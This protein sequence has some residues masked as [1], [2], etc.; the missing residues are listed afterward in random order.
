MLCLVLGSVMLA[1]VWMTVVL[2]LP[3]IVVFG[4]RVVSVLGVGASG[5]GI[6]DGGVQGWRWY[7]LVAFMTVVVPTLEVAGLGLGFAF[8]VVIFVLSRF[9]GLVFRVSCSGGFRWWC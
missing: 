7:F 6:D 2:M 3:M 1:L 9:L 5:C 8:G 4:V